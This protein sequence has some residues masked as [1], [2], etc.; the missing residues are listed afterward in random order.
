MQGSYTAQRVNII[1]ANS[2]Q[3]FKE[4]QVKVPSRDGIP[5][6]QRSFQTSPSSRYAVKEVVVCV[7]RGASPEKQHHHHPPS[8]SP[9]H[10]FSDEGDEKKKRLLSVDVSRRKPNIF[11][12]Y[13]CHANTDPFHFSVVCLINS[14]S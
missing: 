9:L 7:S 12:R 1:P 10:T 6:E 13:A 5:S 14:I 4:V 3:R 11:A 8:I 2:Q